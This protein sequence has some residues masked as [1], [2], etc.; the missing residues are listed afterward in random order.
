MYAAA[1]TAVT[2]R[3]GLSCG[4]AERGEVR[5]PAPRDLRRRELDE[6]DRRRRAR[7]RHQRHL[8]LRERAI[9][10]PVVARRAGGD[11]VLPDRVAAAAA[12]NDVVEGEPARAGAAVDAAPAVAREE[13]ATRDLALHRPRHAHVGDEPD[14]VRPR[15]GRGGGRERLLELL[16]HLGLALVD[17]HVRTP[18]GAHVEWLVAGVQNENVLHHRRNLASEPAQ[19]ARRNVS[20]RASFGHS[21]SAPRAKR[22]SDGR[23]PTTATSAAPRQRSNSSRA[24]RTWY[25]E[26]TTTMRRQPRAWA[27][28]PTVSASPRVEKG[29]GW[30]QRTR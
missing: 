23:V 10:L 15:V 12:R 27:I 8:R 18:N 9:P 11:D 5:L 14:D 3:D 22:G 13:R 17:E 21:R 7:G 20:A 4:G 24:R 25:S 30:T 1:P 16:D 6:E 28:R 2:A 19:Q 26:V 29:T